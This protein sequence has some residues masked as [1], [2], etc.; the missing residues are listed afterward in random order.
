[1]WVLAELIE[2]TSGRDFRVFLRSRIGD[3]L[4]L[5][6]LHVGLP[7]IRAVRLPGETFLG[8]DLPRD[9]PSRGSHRR[10]REEAC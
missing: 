4:G 9:E 5:P 8:E 1:M 3:P 10:G 2:R 6:D 7:E